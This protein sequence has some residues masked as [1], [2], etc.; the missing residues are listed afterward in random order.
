MTIN[1][2]IEEL[3]EVEEKNKLNGLYSITLALSLSLMCMY[4]FFITG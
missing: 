4:V 1:Q 3:L 2:A